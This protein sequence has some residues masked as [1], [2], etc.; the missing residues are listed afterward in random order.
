MENYNNVI[1]G[2]TVENAI[3]NL[4]KDLYELISLSH[5]MEYNPKNLMNLL[6]EVT[7]L[8]MVYDNNIISVSG[9]QSTGKTTL[10]KRA[11]KLPEDILKVNVGVGEKRPVIIS[12]NTD[13]FENDYIY[14]KHYI[15]NANEVKIQEKYIDV[16]EFNEDVENPSE[17]DLWFEILLPQNNE[18]N[19][20]NMKIALLPGIERDEE[21]NSQKFLKTFINC[22]TGIILTVNHDRMATKNQSDLIDFISDKY[23]SKF[24]G[25]VV[26]YSNT[27]TEETKKRLFKTLKDKFDIKDNRQIITTDTD[28]EEI[29]DKFLQLI[30]ENSYYT[31]Q[32]EKMGYE[33][34]QKFTYKLSDEISILEEI[35]KETYDLDNEIELSNLGR[36]IKKER[37][38]YFKTFKTNIE[39]NVNEYINKCIKIAND[40]IKKE[41]KATVSEAFLSYF[42]QDLTFKEKE[43]LKDWV[44]KIY[45]EGNLKSFRVNIINSIESI[46]RK[47]IRNSYRLTNEDGNDIIPIEEKNSKNGKLT[48]Y[49]NKLNEDLER[50][51]LYLKQQNS[52]I[53]LTSKDIKI[54]PVIAGT[55]IQRLFEVVLMNDSE[56]SKVSEESLKNIN[57][58]KKDLLVD[59]KNLTKGLVVFFG[60]D[61]IDGSLDTVKA[62]AEVMSFIGISAAKAVPAALVVITALSTGNL[63]LKGSRKIEKYKFQRAEYAENVLRASGEVQ[64]KQLESIY[65]NFMDEIE[66]KLLDAFERN[67][68]SVEE[69]ESSLQI[70]SRIK[71]VK[72]QIGVLREVS[73]RNAKNPL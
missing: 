16:S 25:F 67:N 15:E 43:E 18:S 31:T 26:T 38:R 47:V 14:K 24:P 52:D 30:Y 1:D 7:V 12:E 17:E 13:Q 34:I 5:R 59:S 48:F 33:Q 39:N 40:E 21:S 4:S 58:E 23:K 53:H 9:L 61:A 50:F 54:I 49:N 42:K 10:V 19:L 64:I 62:L 36:W 63:I 65:N 20:K 55:F 32:S 72:N 22:S 37:N 45:Q 8:K 41:K 68:F 71:R 44:T 28:D 60:I 11:L 29:T 56:N 51:N 6:S 70:Y 3:S 35:Y 66:E 27:L 73:F 57:F 69:N 2:I 46:N